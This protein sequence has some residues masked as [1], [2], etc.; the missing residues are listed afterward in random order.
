[1]SQ[2]L[3]SKISKLLI[4]SM[5]ISNPGLVTFANSIDNIVLENNIENNIDNNVQKYIDNNELS[6]NENGIDDVFSEE[7]DESIDDIIIEENEEEYFIEDLTE[8]NEEELCLENLNDD[9]LE[10]TNEL[11]YDD[12]TND[13]T[14]ENNDLSSIEIKNENFETFEEDKIE[15]ITDLNYN[16]DTNNDLEI[17]KQN[18]FDDELN[19]STMSQ[20]VVDYKFDEE[21][22]ISSESEVSTDDYNDLISTKSNTSILLGNGD[23]DILNVATISNA[24]NN[25][26]STNSNIFGG[27]FLRAPATPISDNE[28]YIFTKNWW[29]DLMPGWTE[30]T[31]KSLVKK[32]NI[33]PM[34]FGSYYQSSEGT[35]G[36][37]SPIK[38]IIL[39]KSHE[40]KTL[41]LSDKILFAEEFGLN[42]NDKYPGWAGS[43]IRN[44]LN[45]D[46]DG[47]LAQAFTDKEREFILTTT[48]HTSGQKNQYGNIFSGGPDVDDKIFILSVDEA[49]KYFGS[50]NENNNKRIAVNTGFVNANY[51]RHDL[52]SEGEPFRYWLRN[53]AYYV[54]NQ[55]AKT[56]EYDGRIDSNFGDTCTYSNGVRPMLWVNFN[57]KVF[58]PFD[59]SKV[60]IDIPIMNNN[61][62]EVAHSYFLVDG[63][64]EIKVSLGYNKFDSDISEIFSNFQNLTEVKG[65]SFIDSTDTLDMS[66]MFYNDSKLKNLD[67]GVNFGLNAEN[68]ESMFE[69]TQITKIPNG[70][71]TNNATNMKRLFANCHNL[72]T[73]TIGSISWASSSVDA[74]ELLYNC[75][76]LNV[77]NVD[78]DMRGLPSNVISTDMFMGCINLKGGGGF[79][80][81][82]SI[83]DGTYA[84]VD[85][86]GILPGYFT[87]TD[88]SIYE[89]VDLKI[90]NDWADNI[91]KSLI[92][93]IKFVNDEVM[94]DVDSAFTF[95]SSDGF[96]YLKNNN[97]TLVIHFANQIPYLKTGT[98]WEQFFASFI[99]LEILEGLGNIDTSTVTTMNRAFYNCDSLKIIDLGNLDFS[100]AT[101][102]SQMFDGCSSLTTIYVDDNFYGLPET[103]TDK[104]NMFWGCDS[105]VGGEGTNYSLDMNSGTYARVDYGGIMPGY[106]TLKGTEEEII[107]KYSNA[108]FTLPND[109]YHATLRSKENVTKIKFFNNQNLGS[110]DESFPMSM[111]STATNSIAYLELNDDGTSMVKIH[112]GQHIPKL[113]VSSDFSRF[114]KDFSN[115]HTIEGFELVDTTNV[116]KMNELFSGCSSLKNITFTTDFPNVSQMEKI[117]YNC[118]DLQSVNIDNKLNLG[119][120]TTLE[121]A[122]ENCMSL[123]S[124]NIGIASLSSIQNLKRAFKNCSSL[125]EFSFDICDTPTLNN[126]EEMFSGCSNLKTIYVSDSFQGLNISSYENMFDGCIKLVGG[127][128]FLYNDSFKSGEYARVDYGGIMPGF[129]TL[130]D[131]SKYANAIFNLP[132]TW[133]DNFTSSTGIAKSLITKIKFY[134][135]KTMDSYVDKFYISDTDKTLAYYSD[136]GDGSYTLQVHFGHLIPYLKVGTDWSGFFKDFS[137]LTSIEGLNL[138]NVKD[139]ENMSELFSGCSSLTNLSFN[140]NTANVTNMSKMFYNCSNLTSLALGN[141]FK[142]DKVIDLSSAFEGCKSLSN[143]N[144][145][146]ANFKTV[147]NLNKTFKGCESLTTFTF[148]ISDTATLTDSSEMFS[149]C[150]NLKTIYVTDNFQGLNGV[151]RDDMF[152]DCEKLVGGQGYNYD[153]IN[154]PNAAD[155]AYGRVDYG[156]IMPGYFTLTNTSKYR[157]AEF[158]LPKNWFNPPSVSGITKDDISKIKFYN[159][160]SGIG[161]YDV[162]FNISLQDRTYGY[163]TVDPDDS[164]KYIAKIHFGH[165]IPKLIV[166]TDFSEF[167]KDF[168]NMTSIEGINLLDLKNVTNMNDTFS[169]CSSITSLNFNPAMPNVQSMDRMFKNC[170]SLQNVVVGSNLGLG[171]VKSMESIF[172]NCSSLTT[173][174]L[175]NASLSKVA[176]LSN[177]FKNC[178]SLTNFSLNLGNS[179]ELM[180]TD[181]MF[182]GCSSLNTVDATKFNMK[183]VSTTKEMFASCTNLTKILVGS[184]FDTQMTTDYEKMFYNCSNLS[185]INGIKFNNNKKIIKTM[186]SIFEGCSSIKNIDLSNINTQSMQMDGMSSMFK[187]CSNLENLTFGTGFRLGSNASGNNLS[188]MFSGCEKLNILDLSTFEKES[189]SGSNTPVINITDTFKNCKNLKTIIAKTNFVSP[190]AVGSEAFLN[191]DNL[192]GGCGTR[193]DDS[194]ITASSYAHIDEGSD[195]PGYFTGDVIIITFLGGDGATGN[196]DKQIA[197]KSIP[198]KINKNKFVKLGF[199]FVNW[200]DQN[201]KTYTTS[202]TNPTNSLILTAQWKK[203]KSSN[204]PSSSGGG[205]GGGGGSNTNINYIKTIN[206]IDDT[207][208]PISDSRWVF[209]SKGEKCGIEVK[210]DSLSG[211]NI[212]NK[213]IYKNHYTN[214]TADNYLRL[215][216]GM[217]NIEYAGSNYYFCFDD[218][219]NLMTGFVET[220]PGKIRVG[221]NANIPALNNTGIEKYYLYSDIGSYKGVMWSTPISIMNMYYVFD[222]YGRVISETP[223]TGKVATSILISNQTGM[224][225]YKPVSNSWHYY[226]ID[227]NGNQQYYKNGTYPISFLG[228]IDYYTFDESG[229]MIKEKKQ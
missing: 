185:S 14:I 180:K 22:I 27:Y 166:G 93:Q 129:Y 162:I 227:I 97:K 156:G 48:V 133:C 161:D 82:P 215:K 192:E 86:G 66:K 172:E 194:G 50:G 224:W 56:I 198:T 164:T 7:I 61:N 75:D 3:F 31:V 154:N 17:D 150:K 222:Q 200:K 120:V 45:N 101:D 9:I 78:T 158:K 127:Q 32:I 30:T 117:F 71:N 99:N 41:L 116:T 2:N 190:T 136:N 65:L 182:S 137:N 42:S 181:G 228:K 219:A 144:I 170:S 126:T 142:L 4:I 89:N 62:V 36:G 115:L 109:W 81:N 143:M 163:L 110:Y 145:G 43:E 128:G 130:T 96:G 37:K 77:I 60:M 102:T 132:N 83:V 13:E 88:D 141:S 103:V 203:N 173:F 84:R 209:D 165:L 220:T 149:G 134:N 52:P 67:L 106:F 146:I 98:N 51:W 201:G 105:L 195:N 46:T 25:A 111:D 153:I 79:K 202:L 87:C 123:K 100:S 177:A 10:E 28:K 12:N 186:K 91:D 139:V 206:F 208:I 55:Q 160:A 19:I 112:F 53:P 176:T 20:Y 72:K 21:Q 131:P 33:S 54:D 214:I 174:N 140:P 152:L 204:V 159:D 8:D 199:T 34:G 64:L 211:Q 138:L 23:N 114:F 94:E 187:D 207:L 221:A 113:K 70:L 35:S 151:T 184:N 6:N 11:V 58:E 47:F 95:G 157:E 197:T 85:Y 216:S 210:K 24:S 171:N 18:T 124:L 119:K 26:I 80:Y 38:W 188:Y 167:F 225:E 135:S 226:I 168:T 213:N 40:D 178:T 189:K 125:T 29:N 39:D 218:S 175:G 68:I 73:F 15:N 121:S 74:T 63:T 104:S 148:E 49:N 16:T 169:G 44:N 122:F 92:T 108:V 196:M 212:L 90:L 5:L 223:L 155:G 118:N 69:G 229:K 107:K 147:K 179:S 57:Y 217:Y 191:C 76:G 183:N 193:Y 1:M 205:S 59:S